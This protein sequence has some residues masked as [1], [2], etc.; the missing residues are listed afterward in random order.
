MTI[1]QMM[2]MA[3]NWKNPSL[4]FKH[5]LLTYK[6]YKNKGLNCL[7][8]CKF[9]GKQ[10]PLNNCPMCRCV[11][12][13]MTIFGNYFKTM[14]HQHM[15][16]MSCKS[17]SVDED[18]RDFV[19]HRVHANIWQHQLQQWET[20]HNSRNRELAILLMLLLQFRNMDIWH[21]KWHLLGIHWRFRQSNNTV[22]RLKKIMSMPGK[23]WS[24]LIERYKIWGQLVNNVL[25]ECL[26]KTTDW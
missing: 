14:I 3:K 26:N 15:V 7:F 1:L 10:Y 11:C 2:Q 25:L 17:Q 6:C 16:K 23:L 22:H 4:T 21:R 12:Q 8:K 18:S 9:G 20:I 13:H 19:D 5:E 24:K